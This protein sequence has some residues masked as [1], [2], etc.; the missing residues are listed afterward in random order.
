MAI[1]PAGGFSPPSSTKGDELTEKN[2]APEPQESQR[3]DPQVFADAIVPTSDSSA[4]EDATLAASNLT[5][6][7]GFDSPDSDGNGGGGGG[8]G[9]F[10]PKLESEAGNDPFTDRME[11]TNTETE[12]DRS[13]YQGGGQST[14]T[15]LFGMDN[16]GGGGGP[17]DTTTTTNDMVGTGM[18]TDITED[19][20]KLPDNITIIR[21]MGGDDGPSL[22]A[23]ALVAGVVAL[24]V[25]FAGDRFG[26]M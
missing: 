14:P 12:R 5:G 1:I 20:R 13:P 21:D 19:I 25:S 11:N 16:G 7:T 24:V 15:D 9:V 3:G 6:Q 22:G 8:G 18:A 10:D 17:T 2:P 26:G 4:D 23:I